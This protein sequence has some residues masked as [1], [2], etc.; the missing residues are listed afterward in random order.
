MK[1][2][3]SKRALSHKWALVVLAAAAACVPLFAASAN[4]AAAAGPTKVSTAVGPFGTMLVDGSGK[5]AGFALYFITSDAPPS[6]GCRSAVIAFLGHKYQ[7][8][9]PPSDSNA[10]WPAL[11]TKGAPIAGPGVS[12]KLLG[13]VTRPG[14]GTQVTYAGH[15]LYLFDSGPVAVTGEG[16]DEPGIPPDFGL[17]YLISP[18]GAALPWADMLTP[19]TTA[20]GK[21]VLGATMLD[22]GSWHV[23]PLYSYSADSTGTSKCTGACAIAWP[24]L[25][26]SGSPG[27][28][29]G[30]KAGNFGTLKRSDGTLQV[31]YK[32]K[33]LYYYSRELATKGAS[34]AYALVGNGNG[35]KGPGGTFQLVTP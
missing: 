4:G 29:G 35:L 14:I 15:P 23:F 26:T 1:R 22:A 19:T 2:N 11:T 34:G 3:S 12:K 20:A 31:T 30:L 10:D 6:Y 21:T 7:C 18:Q 32:G 24:P 27:L 25:L 33:P 17:W 8:A 5:S 28:S 13:T 16:W 9:G